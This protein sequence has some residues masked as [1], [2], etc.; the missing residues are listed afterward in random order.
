M[1]FTFG[2]TEGIRHLWKSFSTKQDEEDSKKD[3][4]FERSRTK[5]H[6]VPHAPLYVEAFK[7][8]HR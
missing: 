2:T 4:D 8:C 5:G 6:A 3:D 7:T 1:E